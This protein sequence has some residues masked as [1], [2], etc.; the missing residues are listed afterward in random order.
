MIRNLK[1]KRIEAKQKANHCKDIRDM[2]TD[3]IWEINQKVLRSMALRMTKQKIVRNFINVDDFEYELG[4]K[5]DEQI[6]NGNLISRRNDPPFILV[7]RLYRIYMEIVRRSIDDI[8]QT[9]PEIKYEDPGTPKRSK[10]PPKWMLRDP[11]IK[12]TIRRRYLFW[13]PLWETMTKIALKTKANDNLTHELLSQVSKQEYHRHLPEKVG[14][15]HLLFSYKDKP[16]I[17]AGVGISQEWLSKILRTFEAEKYIFRFR[18]RYSIYSIG[19]ISSYGGYR[20]WI[21]NNDHYKTS[22]RNL[23]I[24]R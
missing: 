15:G 20:Y 21:K 13:N 17:Q 10:M 3:E 2:S 18:Q 6:K 22:L 11:D 7:N 16:A 1:I 8:L 12:R 9:N 23:Q 19:W 4:K 24:V 14:V 5:V